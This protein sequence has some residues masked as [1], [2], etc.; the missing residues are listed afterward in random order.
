MIVSRPASVIE[1][2]LFCMT[3]GLS[4]AIF[5]VGSGIADLGMWTNSD[6]ASRRVE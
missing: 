6:A 1:W 3:M 5:M 4:T 2:R